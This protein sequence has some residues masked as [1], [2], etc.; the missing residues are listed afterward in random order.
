MDYQ[1]IILEIDEGIGT[2]R[3][4]RPAKLNALTG[5]MQKE[6]MDALERLEADDGVRVV[7]LIGEGRAFSAGHDIGRTDNDA[8]SGESVLEWR[9]KM[10]AVSLKLAQRLWEFPKPV[11]AAAHGYCLGGSCELA[12]LCDLTIASEDCRFGEPE[13]RY[14]YGS[15][16]LVLPWVIPPKVAREL[17]YTGKLISAQRAYE[18]GMV[19]QIVDAGALEETARAE[20]RQ[21]SGNG[22]LALQI[23]KEGLNRTFEIMGFSSA[24]AFHAG[25]VP[26]LN[27]SGTEEMR[28]FERIRHESGLAAALE[29]RQAQAAGGVAAGG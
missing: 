25:Q 12:M 21:M 8:N 10:Q 15:P 2:I 1:E 16:V 18:L 29:W 26:I 11:I 22:L 23:T 14:G 3:L 24:V 7:I 27:G 4:N 28:E 17:L 19:N 13:I 6:M 9:R 20:A 5:P